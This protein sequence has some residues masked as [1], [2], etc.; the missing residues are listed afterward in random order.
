MSSI[1]A[2]RRNPGEQRP[3]RGQPQERRQVARAEDARG[4][5]ALGAK[6]P[7]A[8]AQ[9]EKYVVLP[10][11]DAAEF[12]ALEAALLDELAPVG[13]LQTVLARRVAVAAWRL[14]R[15]DRLQLEVLE[16]RS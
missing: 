16:F 3:R 12:T 5:G 8:W 4:Q 1:G 9:A 15:A 10:Q 14:T 11:D 13:A 2:A 7:E 6:R